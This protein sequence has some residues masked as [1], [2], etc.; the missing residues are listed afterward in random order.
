MI[1]LT[2]GRDMREMEEETERQGAGDGAQQGL[3]PGP[4]SLRRLGSGTV[5]LAWN[6]M[7]DVAMWHLDRPCVEGRAENGLHTQWDAC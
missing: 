7:C 6:P 2:S 4:G 1:H 3:V 5:A